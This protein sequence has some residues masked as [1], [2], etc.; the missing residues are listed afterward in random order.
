MSSA[1][2]L[3]I[4]TAGDCPTTNSFRVKVKVMLRPMVSR[5]VCLGFKPPPGAQGEILIIVRQLR[6]Y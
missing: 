1:S 3:T 2:V 5:P 6:V 4:L